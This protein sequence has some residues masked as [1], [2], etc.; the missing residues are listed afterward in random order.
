MARGNV[1]G[2]DGGT[3]SFHVTAFLLSM[4]V[5]CF[6][7]SLKSRLIYSHIP[8]GVMPHRAGITVPA[9]PSSV[10]GGGTNIEITG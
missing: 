1:I 6:T 10:M 8:G 2:R 4:V 9:G 7:F 3:T 5:R